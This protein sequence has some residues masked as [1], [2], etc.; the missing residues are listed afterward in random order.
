[1]HILTTFRYIFSLASATILFYFYHCFSWSLAFNDD[2]GSGNLAQGSWWT[3]KMLLL[4]GSMAVHKVPMM[5]VSFVFMQARK[6]ARRARERGQNERC[7]AVR[8]FMNWAVY[9][10]LVAGAFAVT[11]VLT[12]TGFLES[13]RGDQEGVPCSCRGIAGSETDWLT[14]IGMLFLFRT[15]VYRPLYVLVGTL[16]MLCL[17]RRAAHTD[18]RRMQRVASTAEDGRGGM[19]SS[20]VGGSIDV[21][22]PMVLEMRA[23]A[24]GTHGDVSAGGNTN[25]AIATKTSYTATD[26]NFNSESSESSYSSDGEDGEDGKDGDSGKRRTRSGSSAATEPEMTPGSSGLRKMRSNGAGS[27]VMPVLGTGDTVVVNP[28]S[29]SALMH[30]DST[31]MDSA[32]RG[33]ALGEQ[34]EEGVVEVKEESAEERERRKAKKKEK[35]KKEKKEKK[36]RDKK[37]AKEFLKRKKERDTDDMPH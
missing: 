25:T 5:L 27:K 29:R 22:N 11:F 31:R 3:G 32:K 35:K 21:D 26:T 23:I 19:P 13:P 6:R 14:L 16:L 8:T 9:W 12:S 1:M 20:H 33:V 15:T 4:A 17:A 2:K 28:V 37:K 30:A 24:N 18:R 36:R 34:K 10:L 7:K